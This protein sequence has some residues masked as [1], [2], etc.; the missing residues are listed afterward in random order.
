MTSANRTGVRSGTTSSLGVRVVS[1]SRREASVASELRLPPMGDRRWGSVPAV[2]AALMVS[3]FGCFA[4]RGVAEAAA[5]EA[6]I[7][8]VE[9]R[10]ACAPPAHRHARLLRRGD[11]VD[12]G[13]IVERD[14][15]GRADRE[16]VVTGDPPVAEDV[17]R[18]LG[19]AVDSKL[20]NL[21]AEGCTQLSGRP[22]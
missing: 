11:R 12:G 9:G 20:E 3:P 7:D 17:E 2:A 1:A 14:D 8:V 13:A 18:R 10:L 22:Q 6:E 5:R 15:H 19:I 21:L 16:R 4:S